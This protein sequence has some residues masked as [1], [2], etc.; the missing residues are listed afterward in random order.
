MAAGR[1]KVEAHLGRG[2][3]IGGGVENDGD[4]YP[5]EAEYDRAL[6]CY[7]ITPGPLQGNREE[8]GGTGVYEE[9][10]AGGY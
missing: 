2:G 6:R 8:A 4:I 9:V 10:G 7:A 3:Q 5:E 1:C